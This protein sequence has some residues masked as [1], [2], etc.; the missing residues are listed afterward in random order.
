MQPPPLERIDG[1]RGPN[2]ARVMRFGNLL[3]VLTGAIAIAACSSTKSEVTAS[4][5]GDAGST[6]PLVAA[7]PYHFKEPAGYDPKTPTPLVVL[8]HG[9]GAGGIVQ[10]AYLGLNGLSDSKNFLLAYPDGTV[11]SAGKR[12]WNATD[13]CCNF[14]HNPVDDVAYIGQIIDDVSA[15]YNV[16]P[17]RIYLVGHSNGAFMSHRFACE[18]APRVAAIVTLAGMQWL[19]ATKCN[20]A[21][22]VAVLQVHGDADQTIIYTGGSTKS[23]TYPSAHQT[24]ATWAAKNG[25]TGALAATG[26][27]L[28]LEATLAGAETTVERYDGCPASVELWTIHGGSHIPGWT[29]NWP[30]AMWGFLAANPKK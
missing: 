13:G 5:A 2:H 14:D 7:R 25:C 20:P 15:Q 1:A 17:K 16:D 10:Q 12:F 28:D 30:D 27:T 21:N 6:P 18:V 26:Q 4:D 8:L 22:P 29:A 9:Y 24:V 19:D 3:V 23:G 11:D